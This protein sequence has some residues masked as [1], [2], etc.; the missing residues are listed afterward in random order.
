MPQGQGQA[1]R[2]G[3]TPDPGSAVLPHDRVIWGTGGAPSSR[4]DTATSQASSPSPVLA[5][6]SQNRLQFAAKAISS[7]ATQY[8]RGRPGPAV[9]LS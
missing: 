6:L 5:D 4:S 8:R 1:D 9:V 2:P 3:L 7:D